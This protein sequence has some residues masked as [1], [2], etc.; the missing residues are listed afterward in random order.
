MGGGFTCYFI[1]VKVA[2]MHSDWPRKFAHDRF[3]VSTRAPIPVLGKSQGEDRNPL[4]SAVN[5]SFG[6]SYQVDV[7][8]TL[9]VL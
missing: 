4:L 8:Y 3:F 2:L 6:V 5:T 9:H 7:Y 1:I